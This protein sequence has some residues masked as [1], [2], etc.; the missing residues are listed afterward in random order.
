LEDDEE[1][2]NDVAV[3]TLDG[4]DLYLLDPLATME[5]FEAL[6]SAMEDAM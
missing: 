5:D 6:L 1:N 4:L 2:I 3:E